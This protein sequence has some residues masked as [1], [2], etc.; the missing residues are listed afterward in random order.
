M[1]TVAMAHSLRSLVLKRLGCMAEVQM[2]LPWRSLALKQ[3]VCMG[4]PLAL[5]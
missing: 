5:A 2:A 3:P 1:E 4:Q